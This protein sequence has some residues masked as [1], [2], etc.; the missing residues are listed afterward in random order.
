M[1]AFKYLLII[2]GLC[3]AALMSF[4]AV[5]GPLVRT[6]GLAEWHGGV[7]V[8]VAGVLWML[9]ARGW[10]RLSDARGRK[11]VI[12]WALLGLGLTYLVLAL[13]IDWARRVT[14]PLL[15]VLV[16]LVVLRGLM[17]L[18]FAAV[19][20][21]SAAWLA[22]HF[23]PQA[24]QAA[25][26]RLGAVNAIG[27]VIGPL[28]AGLLA[29]QSLG[30]P[31]YVA[32]LLPILAAGLLWWKVPTTAAMPQQAKPMLAFTDPRVRLSVIALF[33]ATSAVL[34]AQ[35]CVGFFAMDRLALDAQGG[36]KVAGQTMAGVG[37]TLIVIQSL[38][39]RLSRFSPRQLI[40]FGALLAAMG[41]APLLLATSA[42][43]LIG[44]YCLAAAGLGMVFPAAQALAANSVQ[45]EEQGLAA[46]TLS[47][48]QG[49]ASVVS[50]LTFTLLYQWHWVLPYLLAGLLLCMLSVLALKQQAGLGTE[51]VNELS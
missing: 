1:R 33:L 10:G 34:A 19:P 2:N 46:G 25:M 42:F 47:A 51:P 43:G 24:R 8:T 49:L 15:I 36:A 48:A 14:L 41:F 18:F 22:D 30:L 45:A 17:G 31:L 3:M 23:P 39:A 44:S 16:L 40:S 37:I 6:L 29:T 12:A 13:Y 11:P 4:V 21:V 38:M 9:S 50:P 28:T 26:A 7:A 27:M 5:I 35:L 32:A 20:V